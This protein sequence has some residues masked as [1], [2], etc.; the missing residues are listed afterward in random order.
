MVIAIVLLFAASTGLKFNNIHKVNN[1][2]NVEQ[3]YHN[4]LDSACL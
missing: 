1:L 3:F 2:V 4:R